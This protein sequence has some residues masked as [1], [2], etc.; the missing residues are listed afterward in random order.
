MVGAALC[1][2]PRCRSRAPVV[3]G[4]GRAALRI[5][6]AAFALLLAG[7]IASAEA[8]SPSKPEVLKLKWR[9]IVVTRIPQHV[10]ATDR[11]VVIQLEGSLYPRLTLIDEQSG[12]LTAVSP[13]NCPYLYPYGSP[14]LS[15]QQLIVSCYDNGASPVRYELDDLHSG[16][17]TAFE[18]SP[19]CPGRCEPVAIGRYWAKLVSD[20]G[21]MMLYTPIDYYLQ[22]LVTGQVVHDPAIPGGT[23]FDDLNAPSGSTPLCSPLRYPPEHQGHFPPTLGSLTFYGQFALSSGNKT[24]EVGSQFTRLQRCGSN[25]NLLVPD[26]VANGPVVASSR[27]VIGIDRRTLHGWFLPSLQRFTIRP[28]L[29]DQIEPVAVTDRTIHIAPLTGLQLWAASLPSPHRR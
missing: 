27:A 3:T 4:R 7:P 12:S 10:T 20:D 17:W 25:V 16:Q 6:V 13:P 14:V 21:V 26:A 18:I 15:G 23:V 24:P 19:Q 11:Y 8:R 22:N 1:A 29:G 2:T 9:R 5:V 28:A